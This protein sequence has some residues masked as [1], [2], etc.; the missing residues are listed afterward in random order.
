MRW[1]IIDEVENVS[2]EL[3]DA[4]Q[5]QLKDST[6][7]KGNPW[8]VDD[9]APRQ[10]AMFGGLNLI[11][12]GDLWQIPPVR[13]LSIAANPFAVRA[14]NASRILEMFWTQGLPHSVAHRFALSQSHRCSD[15]W[16]RSFLAE[17]RAGN[18]SDRMY[19]FVH[20]YPTDVPGSWMPP[21][22]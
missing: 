12:L 8:A 7:D 13:A 3:L 1:L 9:R 14:A 2:V 21:A 19:N 18:L 10:F 5:R 15:E 16:W 11:L 6:R 20:G 22:H 17:A 4:L